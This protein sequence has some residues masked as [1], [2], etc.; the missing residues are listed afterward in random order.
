MSWSILFIG[1][2]ANVAEALEKESSKFTGDSKVEFDSALPHL[3]ALC[4]ENF[5]NDQAILRFEA[6]GHGYSVNGEH[7]TRQC[8][9]KVELMYGNLV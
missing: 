4:K 2:P 1:K 8:Q 9:V 6:N 5:G 7:K 3:T